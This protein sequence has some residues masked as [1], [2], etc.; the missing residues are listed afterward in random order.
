MFALVMK[1]SL[2]TY[3]LNVWSNTPQHF[4]YRNRPEVLYEK[5]LTSFMNIRRLGRAPSV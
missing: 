4:S 1:S 5:F 2:A 3:T